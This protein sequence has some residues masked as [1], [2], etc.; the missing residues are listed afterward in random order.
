MLFLH[1]KSNF[2]L[3]FR[4]RVTTPTPTTSEGTGPRRTDVSP[5]FS[6]TSPLNVPFVSLAWFLGYGHSVAHAGFAT[7][8]LPLLRSSPKNLHAGLHAAPPTA[9]CHAVRVHRAPGHHPMLTSSGTS[10]VPPFL[11]L[12]NFPAFS[13]PRLSLHKSPLTVG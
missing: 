5:T 2:V 10:T 9:T 12:L 8:P 13:L 7:H 11:G 1:H 6:G 3:I 4:V